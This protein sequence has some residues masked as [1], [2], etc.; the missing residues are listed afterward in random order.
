MRKQCYCLGLV[1]ESSEKILTAGKFILENFY[2]NYSVLGNILCL[3][4][5][6]HSARSYKLKKLITAVKAS[7]YHVVCIVIHKI[8]RFSV[9]Y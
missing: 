3:I 6:S 7:A 4:D 1:A 8:H 9:L 2:G 5:V